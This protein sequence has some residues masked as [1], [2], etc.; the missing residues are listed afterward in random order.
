MTKVFLNR[1]GTALPP[2]EVHGAFLR[3]AGTLLPDER[4]RR[5]FARMAARSGIERRYST[6]RPSADPGGAQLDADGF[7]SRG[8]FPGT[9]PRLV[10]YERAALPLALRAVADLGDALEPDRITHLVTASCTGFY[11]P[12]LDLELMHALPLRDTTERTHVGFM[13]CHAGFHALKLARHIVRS[14]PDARVLVV[15]LELCSLHLQETPDME[16]VLSFLLFADGCG[17]A[18]VSA[19]PEGLRLDGFRSARLPDSDELIS[20]RI[21]DNG[22][23]MVLS[24]RVP[25]AIGRMLRARAGDLFGPGPSGPD[26]VWAVHPGGRSILDGVEDALELPGDALAASRAVLRDHGN[27]SSATILFVLQH[28][29]RDPRSGADGIAMGFGPGLTAETLR[30]AVA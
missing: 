19:E 22:F 10:R 30:F 21:G 15:S 11:A 26:L 29:L 14:E 9:G 16:Q 18:L 4:M 7:Y 1:I 25:G 17:A 3:Y 24:G 27:M 2:C 5:L 28:M 13:G 20:W 8:R 6:L 12:G 23:D